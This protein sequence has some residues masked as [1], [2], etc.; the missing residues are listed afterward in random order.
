MGLNVQ[1]KVRLMQLNL[2]TVKTMR[3]QSKLQKRILAHRDDSSKGES[4][5]SKFGEFASENLNNRAFSKMD[6]KSMQEFLKYNKII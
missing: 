2:I 4:S 3:F 1:V 6:I 5:L